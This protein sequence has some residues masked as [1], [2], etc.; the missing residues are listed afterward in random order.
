MSLSRVLQ[1]LLLRDVLSYGVPGATALIGPLLLREGVREGALRQWSTAQT[2]IGEPLAVMSLIVLVYAS[3]YVVATIGWTVESVWD[4][5]SS[6]IGTEGTSKI[7]RLAAWLFVPSLELPAGA[8]EE[9]V[10]HFGGLNKLEGALLDHEVA[11]LVAV[12]ARDPQWF[13]MNIERQWQISNL[14][15][16][17]VGAGVI[18]LAAIPSATSS[19]LDY[20]LVLA[21]T[22]ALL[23]S[24]KHVLNYV[25]RL[26]FHSFFTII[27]TDV[28]RI[29]SPKEQSL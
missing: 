11:C 25:R 21:V 28:E 7:S 14:E 8:R 17:L 4:K 29:A 12:Q 20:A 26:A 19:R 3:G 24:R 15:L 5:L 27:K 2:T 6:V 13:D 22:I 18:C 10:N 9:I 1:N 16:G 23:R